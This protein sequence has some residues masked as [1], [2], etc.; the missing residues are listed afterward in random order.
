MGSMFF[1]KED[2]FYNSNVFYIF[3]EWF[4][5]NNFLKINRELMKL[6]FISKKK[7]YKSWV[8]LK[9][10]TIDFLESFGTFNKT[11]I[12]D[13]FHVLITQKII[14][15]NKLKFYCRFFLKN[16]KKDP[17]LGVMTKKIFFHIV[18]A[19]HVHVK[20]RLFLFSILISAL[21]SNHLIPS[22]FSG[23][24]NHLVQKNLPLGLL[25]KLFLYKFKK[26]G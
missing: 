4:L 8:S 7:N 17:G 21:I 20:K 26:S 24:R 9:F 6:L 5:K 16:I 12:L 2:Y 14:G 23:I 25:R 15:D 13:F 3:L 19:E 22:N 10:L 18:S 11:Y 1:F